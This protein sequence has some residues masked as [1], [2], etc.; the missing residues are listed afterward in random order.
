MNIND[1]KNP[2]A[3]AIAAE[4]LLEAKADIE[5][6]EA[7]LKSARAAFEK[8]ARNFLLNH[9]P[10][11]FPKEPSVGVFRAKQILGKL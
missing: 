11:S 9:S 7:A 8:D 3:A 2:E 10:D 6:Q 4:R 5:R 1:I